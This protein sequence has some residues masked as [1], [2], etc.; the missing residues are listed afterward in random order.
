MS[1]FLFNVYVD[2]L[3]AKLN[4]CKIGFSFAAMLINHLMDADGLVLSSAASL[5][6][7]ALINYSGYVRNLALL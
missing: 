3:S 6:K 2:D 7:P 5:D 1:P 4:Q